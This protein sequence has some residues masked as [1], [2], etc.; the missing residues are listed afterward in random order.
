VINCFVV[1]RK[2]LRPVRTLFH[3]HAHHPIGHHYAQH[4]PPPQAVHEIVCLHKSHF[5]PSG[6]PIG[7]IIGGAV[8]IGTLAAVGGAGALVL[9]PLFSPVTLPGSP[10]NVGITPT[11]EML[12]PNPTPVPEPSSIA[13]LLSALILLL[14]HQF[15]TKHGK[16]VT[17]A[18][19]NYLSRSS[20]KSS[21]I[22][23]V[24]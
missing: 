19:Y 10:T 22:G 12:P 2:I 15:L 16:N 20:S 14:L 11:V 1:S 18:V 3:R 5:L 17:R 9:G 23:G 13:L 8:G 4:Y 7:G 6:L 21:V 24:H